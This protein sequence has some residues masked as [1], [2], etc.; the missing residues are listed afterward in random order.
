[1][2]GAEPQR[3]GGASGRRSK[4]PA[5]STERRVR[6]PACPPASPTAPPSLGGA[7]PAP[8]HLHARSHP[9]P[10]VPKPPG[11]DAPGRR[12]GNAENQRGRR[13][14]AAS[15]GGRGGLWV[16]GRWESPVWQE[17]GG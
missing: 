5:S 14:D 10:P 1:M 12:K 16:P 17:H 4:A 7:A 6:G 8:R 11:R 2:R 15:P 13:K 9:R 3:R